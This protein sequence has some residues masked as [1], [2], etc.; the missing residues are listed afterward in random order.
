MCGKMLLRNK[1]I[2]LEWDMDEQAK[3]QKELMRITTDLA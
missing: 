3:V 1:K 2:E